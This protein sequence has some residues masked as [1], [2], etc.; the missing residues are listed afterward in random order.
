VLF[1]SILPVKKNTYLLPIMPAQV[2]IGAI[3][4]AALIATVRRFPQKAALAW[5]QAGIG[6]GAGITAVVLA[7]KV[8][9]I[10][11]LVLAALS[12]ASACGA[13]AELRAQQGRLW[14]WRQVIA[15]TLTIIVIFDFYNAQQDNERS[16]KPVC[17]ELVM[18]M[19]QTGRTL[20]PGHVPE[21]AA[22]YL[23][24]DLPVKRDATWMLAI[25]DDPKNQKQPLPA[26]FA[27][28][29][30]WRKIVAVQRVPMSSAPGD[31]R[32]KVYRL[33]FAND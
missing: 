5:V 15:Y 16:A 27:D 25:V 29:V 13:V 1:F 30:P 20:A 7:V 8:H 26:D 19:Q 14:M 32:W 9:E 31:A 21:E 33:Q 4:L 2:M 23:P 6:I 10:M 11:A 24:L 18:L 17:Q 3:G 12:L 22:L 28:R